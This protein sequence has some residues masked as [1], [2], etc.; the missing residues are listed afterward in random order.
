M[1][2]CQRSGNDAA[3]TRRRR[4]LLGTAQSGKAA[5]HLARM[6]GAMSVSMA[7]HEHRP[8]HDHGQK[9]DQR[10]QRDRRDDD[11]HNEDRQRRDDKQNGDGDRDQL[12]NAD[13][14]DGRDP[15]P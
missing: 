11:D 2:L 13:R 4:R 9:R 7:D 14:R 1:Q 15:G 10:R 5:N 3:D 6:S 8:H 12:D